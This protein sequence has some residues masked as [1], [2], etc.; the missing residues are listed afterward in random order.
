MARFVSEKYILWFL[1]AIVLYPVIR[2]LLPILTPFGIGFALAAAAD[3]A[4]NWLNRKRRFPRYVASSIGVSGIFLLSATILVFVTSLL[5][6]QVGQLSKWLPEITAA[7]AQGTSLLQH[8]LLEAIAHLPDNIHQVMAQIVTSI[9]DGSSGL[10]ESAAG[11][12]TQL[13]GNAL[14]RLSHG[15]INLITTILSAFMFSVRMPQLK[16]LIRGKI[17]A[18]MHSTGKHFRKTFGR[19]F[20]AQ[21]KLAAVAFVLLWLGF[22]L[23][24]IKKALLWAA[25][26]TMVDILPILG[27][28]TALIPWSIVCYLQGN[29]PKALGLIGIFLLIWLVRSVLE[30]KLVGKELGL[31][32]LLTLACIYAGLRLW[33]IGGMLLAPAGAVCLAQFGRQYHLHANESGPE[34]TP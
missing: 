8:W 16:Q 9:F 17:P 15:F 31:D 14:G 23:L 24:K 11:K 1:L 5:L 19:W 12:L 33:G 7:I 20:L 28:G 34:H 10:L 30:P 13:V 27:V 3:P 18:R 2:Q 32:P 21:G 4:V 22:C 29:G 6:R 25:L 26:V